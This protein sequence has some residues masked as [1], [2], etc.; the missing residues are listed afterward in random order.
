[1][2]LVS[3]TR[4]R[5]RSWKYLPA[6]FVATARSVFQARRAKGNLAISMLREA[7]NT[8]WTRSL[9][10]DEAAMLTFMT[11]GAHRTIMPN[12]LEWCDEAS[13]ARWVQ[14]S[15]EKPGWDEVHRRMQSEGRPS[16]V[17]HPSA[18][19]R[20]YDLPPPKARRFGELR[21]K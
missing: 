19:H 2:P 1:M 18:A 16:K 11:S 6:F 21:L 5:V 9:W 17:N 4:L 7:R 10:T 12:L 14:D 8:F 13:V 3:I 15:V 20:A